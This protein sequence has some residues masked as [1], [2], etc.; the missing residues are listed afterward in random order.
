MKLWFAA[1]LAALLSALGCCGGGRETAA[2]TSSAPVTVEN[3]SVENYFELGPN[4][5]TFSHVPERIV[6]VGA[7]ESETLMDLGVTRGVIAAVPT[8]DNPT[9]GIKACNRA[10]F[11]SFPPM[12]R[13]EVNAERL[14]ALQP[15]LIVAQQE[16]FSK[17]RLGSTAYW[18]GKGVHTM[19]PLNTTAPG[20]LNAVET[21]ARE[22]KFI[23]DMGTIF[24]RDDAAEKI[25]GDTRARIDFIRRETQGGARPKVMILD[26]MSSIVAS[27]GRDKIAGDMAAAIGADVPHTTAA[28]GTENIMEENPDVVFVVVYDEQEEE[29]QKIRENP[30]FRHLNFIQN[31]R[32]YPIPLKFVYGPQTRTIDAIGYMANRMYP[33]QFDFAT[34]YDFHVE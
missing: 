6:V 23:R 25:I 32:L 18:N 29:V 9:F 14:L 15:D 31:N 3:I 4:I 10:A 2:E 12:K 20:K 22:M 19:V 33:G 17:N 1:L 27:Y 34:E 26:L 7:N 21:I 28:V 24:R 13:S 30:A 16:F 11:A 5:E 8:Q